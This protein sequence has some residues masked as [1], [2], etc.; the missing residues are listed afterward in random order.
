MLRLFSDYVSS[1]MADQGIASPKPSRKTQDEVAE[2]TAKL[3]G[4]MDQAD[5]ESDPADL[6]P[7]RIEMSLLGPAASIQPIPMSTDADQGP[8]TTEVLPKVS[9]PV[10]VTSAR[11]ESRPQ[12]RLDTFVARRQD[13]EALRTGHTPRITPITR[14]PKLERWQQ[15]DRNPTQWHDTRLQVYLHAFLIAS[16][17]LILAVSNPLWPLRKRSL[18]RLSRISF[19]YTAATSIRALY[20]AF[21][22]PISMKMSEKPGIQYRHVSWLA[23]A[24]RFTCFL[25]VI[26]FAA[27]TGSHPYNGTW[28]D[29]FYLSLGA[30]LT[31][32]MSFLVA[33]VPDFIC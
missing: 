9:S 22:I 1:G 24:A 26:I 13:T 20:G 27:M 28:A 12:P 33:I 21:I 7:S 17:H 15:S 31:M 16:A 25:L 6:D 14:H 18:A 30:F 8:L 11:P 3:P 29:L 5:T 2:P 10:A 19:G 4:S 32:V 23:P